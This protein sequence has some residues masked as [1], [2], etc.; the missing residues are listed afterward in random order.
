MDQTSISLVHYKIQGRKTMRNNFLL[1]CIA[2]QWSTVVNVR[3]NTTVASRIQSLD[4]EN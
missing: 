4:T 1:C 3:K 2:A